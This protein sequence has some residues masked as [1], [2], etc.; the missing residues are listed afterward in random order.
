MRTLEVLPYRSQK[1]HSLGREASTW[2]KTEGIPPFLENSTAPSED[3]TVKLSSSPARGE[4]PTSLL[5]TQYSGRSSS[6]SESSGSSRVSTE[7]GSQFV[8]PKARE[9]M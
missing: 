6:R 3:R 5:Q 7:L 1:A 9:P 4:E 2:A 8:R